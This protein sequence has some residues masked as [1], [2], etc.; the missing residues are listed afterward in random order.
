M[1][2]HSGNVLQNVEGNSSMSYDVNRTGC[3]ECG[4]EMKEKF[5]GDWEHEE[6]KV[7]R[8][9]Y[10]QWKQEQELIRA[11]LEKRMPN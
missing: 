10:W 9:N 2:H 1:G 5:E 3:R 6:C 7:R 8:L 4:G 11:K